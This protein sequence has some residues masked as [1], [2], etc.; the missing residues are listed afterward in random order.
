[1]EAHIAELQRFMETK[2]SELLV[3][4]PHAELPLSC[5]EEGGNG[6]AKDF[7]TG[8]SGGRWDRMEAEPNNKDAEEENS[9]H[10]KISF[11]NEEPTE[12]EE[13]EVKG[14]E[15]EMSKKGFK[16]NF[17]PVGSQI[18]TAVATSLTTTS[19]APTPTITPRSTKVLKTITSAM[20]ETQAIAKRKPT[21]VASKIILHKMVRKEVEYLDIGN[22]K[23]KDFLTKLLSETIS[24]VNLTRQMEK[25]TT[26]LPSRSRLDNSASLQMPEITSTILIPFI[27][28]FF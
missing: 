1:M 13:D 24:S 3:S 7:E 5:D 27:F 10:G 20:E 22:I 15:R 11:E 28:H 26:N 17:S 25:D 18:F 9:V 19:T 6:L 2:I 12:M 23:D 8:K 16:A 4:S 14:S 21:N